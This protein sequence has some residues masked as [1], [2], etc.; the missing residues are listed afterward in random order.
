MYFD[1]EGKTFEEAAYSALV[2]M[3]ESEYHRL[4]KKTNLE[5]AYWRSVTKT[6]TK[7]V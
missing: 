3:E 2:G 4:E 1:F 6:D 5:F 7:K